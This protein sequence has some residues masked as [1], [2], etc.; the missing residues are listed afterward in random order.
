M[1]VICYMLRCKHN[2]ASFCN[3]IVIKINTAQMCICYDEPEDGK[4]L[5][6]PQNGHEG[7]KDPGGG[8]PPGSLRSSENGP[9][10]SKSDGRS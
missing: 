4:W 5:K 2:E 8:I 7:H 10:E 9:K 1:D 3:K 6:K